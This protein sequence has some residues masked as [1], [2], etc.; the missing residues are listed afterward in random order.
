MNANRETRAQAEMDLN[1]DVGE[2]GAQDEELFAAGI[3]SANIAC[4]AHAGDAGTMAKSCALA[5]THGVMIGAHPGYADRPNFGRRAIVLSNADLAQLLEAQLRELAGCAARV[6]RKLAHVKPHGALYHALNNDP[7]AAETLLAIMARC[8]PKAALFG[9]PA[10][11]LRDAAA[12][13]GCVFVPEGFIDRGYLPDGRLVPRGEPGDVLER[14]DEIT[15]QTLAQARAGHVR[16]LC[17]H[18]D[19]PQAVRWLQLARAALLAE[20]FRIAPPGRV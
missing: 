14:G 4:G 7:S 12:R 13:A 19:G 3:T 6:G 20:G 16:T 18:G 8:V 11:A 2:G 15:A 9:P 17:V 10:G 1:A 5:A